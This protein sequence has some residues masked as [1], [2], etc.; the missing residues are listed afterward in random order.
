MSLYATLC[1]KYI[2]E[3]LCLSFMCENLKHRSGIKKTIHVA[4]Q[5]ESPDK[6][7]FL[8]TNSI[9][10]RLNCIYAVYKLKNV[11]LLV[12]KDELLP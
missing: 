2:I 1:S 11:I 8:L 7:E 9:N 6:I 4:L 12:S 3:I 5:L 10:Y